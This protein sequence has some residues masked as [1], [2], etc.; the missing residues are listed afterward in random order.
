M[1]ADG[2]AA[3]KNYASFGLTVREDSS[4]RSER[5]INAAG[6]GILML[7]DKIIS[8]ASINR[9]PSVAVGGNSPRRLPVSFLGPENCIVRR[10]LPTREHLRFHHVRSAKHSSTH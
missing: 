3:T 8:G 9:V 5:V 4:E 10:F 7:R 1:F 2:D 6:R